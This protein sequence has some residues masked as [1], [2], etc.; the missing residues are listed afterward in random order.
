MPIPDNTNDQYQDIPR[1]KRPRDGDNDSSDV[2]SEASL[3][4]ST[5]GMRRASTELPLYVQQQQQQLSP[6]FSLP[7]YSNELGRL[8]I[9]GQFQFSDSVSSM[10]VQPSE[11]FVD[12]ISGPMGTSY[13]I[14]GATNPLFGDE[15][16]GNLVDHNQG[17]PCNLTGFCPGE[18]VFDID[19]LSSFGTTPAMDNATMAAWSAAPTN[20]ECV[21][22][23]FISLLGNQY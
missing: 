8:P 4:R 10:P 9:Y 14:S 3:S 12:M 13:N 11:D 5:A 16:M 15:M 1:K 6:N 7:M 18:D 22:F 23:P 2:S 17:I 21:F 20:L 19:I